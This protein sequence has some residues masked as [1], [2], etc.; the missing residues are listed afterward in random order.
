MLKWYRFF[1][2]SWRTGATFVHDVLALAIFVV[3]FGHVVFAL[4]HRD[5]LRSMIKGWVTEAWARAHASAW[6]SEEEEVQ[7][8]KE[9]VSSI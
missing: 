1:P 4:T 2:L 5:A 6:L 9:P 7:P 8:E 3:V